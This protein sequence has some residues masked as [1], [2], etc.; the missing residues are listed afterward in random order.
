M[1]AIAVSFYQAKVTDAALRHL[2]VLSELRRLDLQGTQVTD[3]DLYQLHGLKRLAELNLTDTP[4]GDAGLRELAGLELLQTLNLTNT[5]VT[6]PGL[7]HLT[8]LAKLSATQ[9]Q[10]TSRSR[11]FCPGRGRRPC[12]CR[13]SSRRCPSA[14]GRA[15]RAGGRGPDLH[16]RG[17]WAIDL[18]LVKAH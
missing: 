2:A 6:G 10:R 16:V 1:P 14:A 15:V 4:V 8:G 9:P 7:M 13:R 18:L 12:S 3:A 11:R 17:C 5:R